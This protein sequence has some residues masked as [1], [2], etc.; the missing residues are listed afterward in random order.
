MKQLLPISLAV[1]LVLVVHVA[2]GMALNAQEWGGGAG[3]GVYA[4]EEAIDERP[5]TLCHDKLR[6][7]RNERRQPRRGPEAP[8]VA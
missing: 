5:L 4:S 6:C 7:P 2:L 1:S 8:P 3:E